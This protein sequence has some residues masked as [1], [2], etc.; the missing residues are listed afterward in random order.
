[1]ASTGGSHDRVDVPEVAEFD[2]AIEAVNEAHAAAL[3]AARSTALQRDAAE[4]YDALI[5]EA[6][7]LKASVVE[8]GDED[9]AARLL[10]GE[11]AAGGLA[12]TLRLWIAFKE[13]DMS[14][15]WNRM[16]DAQ[17]AW[18][19]ALRAHPIGQQFRRLA[20]VPFEVERVLFPHV[21]FMSVGMVVRKSECT[22]CGE[23]PGECGHVKGRV[24]AGR[25]AG[26]LV[27]EADLRETSLVDIPADKRCRIETITTE[28]VTRDTLTWEVVSAPADAQE[29][30]TPDDPQ[31][32]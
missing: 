18:T 15:A 14:T 31:E 10:C 28:G 12:S 21:A 29:E 9:S 7:R 30:S 22:I 1:M 3:P 24:Y 11:C 19:G 27:T 8:R 16:V 25:F 26:I 6:A 5:Q 32:A 13:G 23:T 17:Q 4:A 20:A 2:A